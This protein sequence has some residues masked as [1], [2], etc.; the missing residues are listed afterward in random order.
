MVMVAKVVF[1][2]CLICRISDHFRGSLFFSF[3]VDVS[4]FIREVLSF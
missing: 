1:G 2:I 4:V 3:V